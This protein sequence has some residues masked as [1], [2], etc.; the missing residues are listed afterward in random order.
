MALKFAV[1]TSVDRDDLK[2]GGASIFA[3]TIRLTRERVP[4]CRIEVLIPTSRAWS[5]R[6]A[7]CST[8][9]RTC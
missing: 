2:D 8:R 1:I 4:D 3:E 5:R 9:A 6:C 7:R